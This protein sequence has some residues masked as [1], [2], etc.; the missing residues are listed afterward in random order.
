MKKEEKLALATKLCDKRTFFFTKTDFNKIGFLTSFANFGVTKLVELIGSTELESMDNIKNFMVS[1][2][3]GRN[4]EIDA[5]PLD[6][7][8][9]SDLY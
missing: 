6:N 5:L 7:L 2:V 8:D 3:E 9:L 4:F 1:T